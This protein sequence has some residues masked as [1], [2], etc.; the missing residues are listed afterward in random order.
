MHNLRMN[1]KYSERLLYVAI[2][3]YQFKNSCFGY[4]DFISDLNNVNRINKILN[5]R[6]DDKY[7]YIILI[8]RIKRMY[9]SFTI[10]CIQHL[11]NEIISEKNKR[12]IYHLIN[13]LGDDY[14]RIK[15]LH[16]D[17]EDL[18]LFL[19]NLGFKDDEIQEIFKRRYP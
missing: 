10:P 12:F 19:Y 14:F 7:N 8:N 2:E 5:K 13:L 6:H 16:D 17:K 18:N 11:V 4:K 15:M 1:N 3:G 9:N